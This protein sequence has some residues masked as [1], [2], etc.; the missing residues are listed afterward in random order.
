[1][2][3]SCQHTSQ[4]VNCPLFKLLERDVGGWGITV[5]VEAR[6]IISFLVLWSCKLLLAMVDNIA[7]LWVDSI[8]L[9][10]QHCGQRF[11]SELREWLCVLV[12]SSCMIVGVLLSIW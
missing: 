9:L 8:M 10:P 6:G 12:E 4:S 2:R 7:T 5:E 11:V 3:C 1:M